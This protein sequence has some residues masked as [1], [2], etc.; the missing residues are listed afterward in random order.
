MSVKTAS[1]RR[2]EFVQ[3][4]SSKFWQI[5]VDG[6]EVRIHFGRIGTSGQFVTKSFA[7]ENAAAKHAEQVT[8]AKLAKGYTKV[9]A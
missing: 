3:G 7:D 6:S 5:E 1:T 9:A 2:F 8:R 4:S